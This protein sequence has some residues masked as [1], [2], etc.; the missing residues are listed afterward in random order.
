MWHGY[1]LTGTGANIYTA[2]VARALRRQ[3]HDVMVMCQELRAAE[4]D[5]VDAHGDFDEHNARYSEHETGAVAA[6]GRCRVIR[7]HIGDVLPVYVYDE[8]EGFSAK[9]YVDLTDAELEHYTRANVDALVA[10]IEDLHP[11]AIIT[12]HEVMGPYIA[13]LAC[14]RTGTRFV[15]KLHG[16]ALEYAV[17]VQERYRRFAIEGLGAA[18]HVVGGSRYMVDAA[19]SYVPGWA[20]RATVV[21]PGADVDLFR[22]VERA[23]PARPTVAYVGKL[24]VSKGVHHLLAAAGLTT[25]GFDLTI[26]GYGRY[27]PE[28]RALSTA[29]AAGDVDTAAAIAAKGDGRPLDDLAAFLRSDDVTQAYLATLAATPVTFEGRLDHGPLSRRLPHVDLLVVPSVVPEAFGMVAAEAAACGVLPVVPDHSGIGEAG[30]AIET[31]VGRPG[32]LTFDPGDPIRGI[33]GAI[34]RVLGLSFDERRSLGAAATELARATWSW[35]TVARRL[36]E[37]AS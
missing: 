19:S 13:R 29:L 3:G 25:S 27:E 7:P 23:A 4:L 31:H 15:A 12:G 35:D 11:H 24:I 30:G 18:H 1:L 20:H 36:L 8:Y 21:N 17:R 6:P 22:P 26:I 32:L 2:N 34:D 28:L 33:A 37:A 9:L 10:A 16:S 5:F 14:E